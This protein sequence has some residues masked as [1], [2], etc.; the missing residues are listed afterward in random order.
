[1]VQGQPREIVH[2]IPSSNGPK[3]LV[4]S[5]EFKPQS[6]KKKKKGFFLHFFL[7]LGH[8]APEM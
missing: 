3:D 1:M 7:M 8:F 6:H 5:P 2:E 4:Q